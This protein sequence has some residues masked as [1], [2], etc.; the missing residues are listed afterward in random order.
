MTD[1][2][3]SITN[4]LTPLVV[5]AASL[6]GIRAD[7]LRDIVV[8]LFATAGGRATVKD[9]SGVVGDGLTVEGTTFINKVRV[10][11]GLL[12]PKGS[13]MLSTQGG[14][15]DNKIA[16]NL[17]L[18]GIGN[19]ASILNGGGITALF[20]IGAATK[21]VFEDLALLSGRILLNLDLIATVVDEIVMRNLRLESAQGILT[22]T[23]AAP[24]SDGSLRIRRLQI[25]DVHIRSMARGL[26]VSGVAAGNVRLTNILAEACQRYGIFI[27]P[28]LRAT[29]TAGYSDNQIY[30]GLVIDDVTHVA[31]DSAGLRIGGRNIAVAGVVV[32]NVHASDL[33]EA[34]CD[35]LVTHA[36]N[37][38]LTGVVVVGG[39]SGLGSIVFAHS[40]DAATTP[41][42]TDGV[43]SGF[44]IAKGPGTMNAK[45]VFGG[46]IVSNGIIEQT[47]NALSAIAS[48]LTIRPA[49]IRSN[50][51]ARV[52]GQFGFDMTGQL[53]G[54]IMSDT[55]IE[56]RGSV[57]TRSAEVI[58]TL[59]LGDVENVVQSG[60]ISQNHVSVPASTINLL[61]V[62]AGLDTETIDGHII[63]NRI[64]DAAGLDAAEV[65]GVAFD[66]DGVHLN[67]IINS[68]VFKNFADPTQAI[69]NLT[70]G[71]AV[72][73]TITIINCLGIVT[74]NFGEI[75]F[76][77][78]STV[79]TI[80]HGVTQLD[81]FVA[82]PEMSDINIK[83]H[84]KPSGP[85]GAWISNIT[86]TQIEITFDSTLLVDLDVSWQVNKKKWTFA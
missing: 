61:Y 84:A 44:V 37:G 33:S 85:T 70:T 83:F 53:K 32:N 5:D 9:D 28:A 63:S 11:N 7:D 2:V 48:E 82:I 60:G 67:T 78:G 55:V 56:M 65:R 23:T 43:L 74:E 27:D 57:N 6:P 69:I 41:D 21:Y 24:A 80:N 47:V 1:D 16:A 50:L 75:T 46:D 66:G 52:T 14:T 29:Q 10:G 49:N 81:G 77:D 4:L 39:G 35:G 22:W 59:E 79:Y 62:R 3:K 76:A 8:S 71:R 36:V 58:D 64:F 15:I 26:W 68:C 73:S 20:D 31:P 17:F 30:T 42:S 54:L 86:A 34:T 40:P 12:I 51:I 19:Y 25:S 45:G 13:Y 72:D 18:Q 38:V